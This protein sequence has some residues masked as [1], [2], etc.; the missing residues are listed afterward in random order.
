MSIDG[1]PDCGSRTWM[2][3]MAA[4][5]SAASRLAVAICSGVIGRPGCCSGL[6]RLPVTAQ[7]MMTFGCM[8]FSFGLLEMPATVDLDHGSGGEAQ[9]GR[10][11]FDGGRDVFRGAEPLEWCGGGCLVIPG[12]IATRDE[13]A[14]DHAG[15]DVEHPYRRRQCAP[16]RG[17]H[18]VQR[19][20]RAA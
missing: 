2:C 17:R 6:V 20:L 5:A 7:V 9:R 15:R 19:R 8:W 13:I 12:R 11:R 14:I 3:T 18:V 1:L 10:A 16:Q 4:P